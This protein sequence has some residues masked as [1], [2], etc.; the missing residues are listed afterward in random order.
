MISNRAASKF[1][2]A[3]IQQQSLY[4]KTT[5]IHQMYFPPTNKG[6]GIRS[7]ICTNKIL[8]IKNKALMSNIVVFELI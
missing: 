6:N 7:S 5:H 1:R 8:G 4:R 2:C 3:Y